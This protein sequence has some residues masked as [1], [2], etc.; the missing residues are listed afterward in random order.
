MLNSKVGKDL[1][2]LLIVS[3]K[4][5]FDRENAYEGNPDMFYKRTTGAKQKTCDAG[6]FFLAESHIRGF[7]ASIST[8]STHLL[9]VW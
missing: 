5:C 1:Y 7:E 3:T 4:P 2:A 8:I 9:N 6:R